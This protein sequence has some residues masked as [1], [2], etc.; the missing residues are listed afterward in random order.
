MIQRI[1]TIFL[2][3]AAGLNFAVL[4]MPLGAVTDTGGMSH[5]DVVL[6]GQSL[7]MS[8]FDESR[9]FEDADGYVQGYKDTALGPGENV[10]LLAHV[11]VLILV[12]IYLIAV[13]FMFNNRPRQLRLSYIGILLLMIQLIIAAVLFMQLPDLA[14]NPEEFQHDIAYGFFFP[15]GAMLLTLLAARRIS[16]DERL[17]RESDRIR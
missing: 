4:F 17:V 2:I 6:T 13:I 15:V 9:V 16:H 10:L 11:V 12:S 8:I 14:N 1:Q 5:T 3:L 7:E